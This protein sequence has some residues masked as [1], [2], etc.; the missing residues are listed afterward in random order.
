[1][2][3]ESFGDVRA[4]SQGSNGPDADHAG[5]LGCSASRYGLG[6]DPYDAHDNILAGAAYLRELL[7][8]TVPLVF[9]LPTMP[10]RRVTKIILRLVGRCLRRHRLTWPPR[11]GDRGQAIDDATVV[12]AVVRS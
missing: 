3:A 6:A 2:R 4:L 10:G 7:D 5:S 1:M 9:W 8:A 11:S 12:N